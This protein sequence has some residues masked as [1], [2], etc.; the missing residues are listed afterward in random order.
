MASALGAKKGKKA[1]QEAALMNTVPAYDSERI[2]IPFP[3]DEITELKIGQ[4]IVI[5]IKGTINRLEGEKF[6]S[7]IGLEV[8]EKSFRKT[9]NSQAEGIRKLTEDED[10]DHA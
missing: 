9:S 7:C 1:K 4:E 2:S 10:Y 5:T 6:Y 3:L 8:A